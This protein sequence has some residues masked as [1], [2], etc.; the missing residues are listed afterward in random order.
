LKTWLFAVLG[1]IIFIILGLSNQMALTRNTDRLAMNLKKVEKA[2]RAQN[3]HEAET[4]LVEVQTEWNRI[5]PTWS[6][7]LHHREIDA[8]DQSLIKTKRAVRARDLP[9][10]EVEQGSLENYIKHIPKREQFNLV[11][12]F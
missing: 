12:I 11:N 2:I 9:A 3:W 1:L 4:Q 7:L 10:A 5:K 8:I 6:L